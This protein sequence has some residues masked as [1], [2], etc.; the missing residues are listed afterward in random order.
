MS[1]PDKT[2]GSRM[3]FFLTLGYPEWETFYGVLDSLEAHG[4][5]FV[6]L[7]VPVSDPIDDGET[8]RQADGQVLP[9][10]TGDRIVEALET[11][12]SRY[13]FRTILMT[14]QEGVE[15]FELA[16]YERWLYDSL[17]CVDKEYSLGVFPNQVHLFSE[18]TSGDEIRRTVGLSSPFAYVV[19]GLGKTGGEGPLPDK[20]RQTIARIREV[21]SIPAFV[22]FGIRSAA[23]VRE[24]LSNG[25]DGA[26]I[27]SEL[28]RQINDDGVAAV[29]GYLDSLGLGAAFGDPS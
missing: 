4:V 22:G 15:E 14:Y 5:G 3:A 18:E 13:S 1:M 17:L 24:V 12:R 9:D 7:G 6:E 29:D 26:I 10:M 2:L 28:I 11:I 25:A 27:G 16:R 20:Y 8:I 21:S 23:D 19:T